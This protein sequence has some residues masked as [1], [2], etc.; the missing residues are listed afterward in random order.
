MSKLPSWTNFVAVHSPRVSIVCIFLNAERFLRE[1]VESVLRQDFEDYELLL[2]DDGS[3][4]ASTG[5]ARN[6]AARSPGK[7][8][9]LKHEGHQNRGMSASRNLGISHSTGEFL[10]FIDADDRWSPEKLREQVAILDAH[11]E[12]AMVCGTVNYWS[13]WEGGEDRL[14]PTGHVL[15]RASAPPHTALKLYPLGMSDAPCPSDVLVRRSAVERIGGFEEQFRTLYEDSAFFTKLFLAFPVWFS[16]RT[17][18]DYRLHPESC[19][20][21]MSRQQHQ[22]VRREFLDWLSAYLQEHRVAQEAHLRRA[23][24]LARWELEHPVAGRLSRRLRRLLHPRPRPRR[25]V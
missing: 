19:L 14:T 21:A 3:S 22:E 7:I 5:I 1:A 4:D 6:L 10:A 13:S 20:A 24:G 11:P 23:I 18:T 12:T 2:V 15:D 16:S 8:R 25:A 9:Y 17:W